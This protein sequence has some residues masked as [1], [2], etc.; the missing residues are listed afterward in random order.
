M[1]ICD[2]CG[3]INHVS[4]KCME[5]GPEF[6]PPIIRQIFYQYNAKHILTPK[7]A[8]VDYKPNPSIAQHFNQHASR[9][10]ISY[11]KCTDTILTD[12]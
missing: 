7:V 6:H 9:P 10:E 8:P 1:I 11:I 5:R 12:Q 3:M 4:D 2:L